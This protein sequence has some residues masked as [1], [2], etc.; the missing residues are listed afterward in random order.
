MRTLSV[1]LILTGVLA[2]A[3]CESTPDPIAPSTNTAAS[4][5]AS[6][7]YDLAEFD[8]PAEMG[9]FTSAFG[10]N[11]AGTIVGN[12]GAPDG[13]AHGFIFRSG[14]F[15]DIVVPGAAGFDLGSVGDINDAG[16]AVG[17]FMDEDF[18]G[19]MYL[20]S[21]QGHFTFL[22]DPEPG[23]SSSASGNNNKGTIVGNFV[24][25][26]GARHGFIWQGGQYTPF[27]AP[28]ARSTRLN[29]VND[30]DE[31]AGQYTDFSGI[32]HGFILHDGVMQ[33]VA[34]PGAVSTR[35]SSINN[36][37]TITG[38]YN[39]ADGVWHGFVYQDGEYTTIDFPGS[40]NTIALGVND[41]GAFVGTYDDFSRGFVATPRR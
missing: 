30:L 33:T 41:K 12:Y 9:A 25:V 37:G 1:V 14:H 11:N 19:H 24:D 39:N 36:H 13:N 7:N 23:A 35:A 6:V 27:D 34:Y 16:I 8:V 26:D 2:V 40:F 10:N 29:G 5:D 15:I 17:S 21:P 18:V 4:L 20:R 22:P 32:V 31:I 3:G 28:G 38:F